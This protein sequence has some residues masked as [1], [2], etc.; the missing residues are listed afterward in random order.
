M[1]M[2]VKGL[3]T[4][5]SPSVARA[6]AIIN[7]LAEHPDQSFKLMDIQRALRLSRTTCHSVLLAL[8]EAGYVNRG[9][10]KS[11]TLGPMLVD[12]GQA[13]SISLS[14]IQVAQPE[15]RQ[16]ADR[17]DVICSAVFLEGKDTVVRDRAA[18]VSYLG[19]SAPRGIRIPVTAPAGAIQFAWSKRILF[20][21]WLNQLSPP[22]SRDAMAHMEAAISFAQQRG[23][24][25]A[26]NERLE[27]GDGPDARGDIGRGW[28]LDERGQPTHKLATRL[29]EGD[30]YSVAV[31]SAPVFDAKAR[32]AFTLTLASRATVLSA[33]EIAHRGQDLRDACDRIT[34]ATGGRAP[35][36]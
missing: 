25:F 2:D 36:V 27:D 28:M 6:V 13:A 15:M 29:D 9:S 21:S 33:K 18:S 10:D 26:F 8:L 35:N 5:P 20:E 11:F 19:F 22:P 12:I 31:I 1:R 34:A 4:R 23:F 3:A 32:R 16:L 30:T 24:S 17:Y 7:F 14:P